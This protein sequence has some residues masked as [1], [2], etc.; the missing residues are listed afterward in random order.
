METS[1]FRAILFG[2]LTI[3]VLTLI[4][5]TALAMIIRFSSIAEITITYSAI[6]ITC[7][8]LFVGGLFA[9]MKGKTNGL[10]IGLLT[11]FGFTLLT[12]LIQFLGY[13][14]LFSLKQILF[15]LLYLLAAMVGGILGVNFIQVKQ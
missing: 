15:H 9:G 4:A 6:I 5:A 8:I 3:I 13:N 1:F 2:W 12:F 7:I 11:G 10:W 14:A